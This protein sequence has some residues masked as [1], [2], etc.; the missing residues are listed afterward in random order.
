MRTFHIIFLVI[1]YI[2]VLAKRMLFF[3]FSFNK[4]LIFWILNAIAV[5]VTIFL[6][7][8]I[9]PKIKRYRAKRQEEIT[10]ISR[11]VRD[12]N[13]PILLVFLA[14]L[15]P[16][17][18][19]MTNSLLDIKRYSINL[20]L[21]RLHTDTLSFLITTIV[22]IILASWLYKQFKK[23]RLRVKGYNPSSYKKDIKIST[24]LAII[25]GAFLSTIIA[26]I[27]TLANLNIT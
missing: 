12:V 4:T 24:Q 18:I 10:E 26:A 25:I 8:K 7:S 3:G 1:F 16:V 23:Y 21:V 11:K 15:N 13:L 14:V 27:Y 22:F 19:W 6:L 9:I 17:Y 2:V 20:G 5:I